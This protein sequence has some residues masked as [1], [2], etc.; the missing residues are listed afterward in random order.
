MI[1]LRAK[2]YY[3]KKEAR[4]EANRK[5]RGVLNN[6][7]PAPAFTGRSVVTSDAHPGG[8]TEVG[9]WDNPQRSRHCSGE[10]TQTP[11]GL[12]TTAFGP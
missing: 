12:G 1:D 11:E 10:L 5:N 7:P 9:G 4:G 8:P 6:F 2:S 3:V